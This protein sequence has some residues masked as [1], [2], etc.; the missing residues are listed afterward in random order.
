[1]L[2]RLFKTLHKTVKSMT[3]YD[4]IDGF[5]IIFL[6][7]KPFLFMV[8]II[9][10]PLDFSKTILFPNLLKTYHWLLYLYESWKSY[11]YTRA[12]DKFYGFTENDNPVKPGINCP[13]GLS[14][15]RY[16]DDLE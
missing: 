1:M 13:S 6:C 11:K 15:G 4:R 9:L 10:A 12:L 3:I 16:P 8:L 14:S 5:E 7:S 2:K